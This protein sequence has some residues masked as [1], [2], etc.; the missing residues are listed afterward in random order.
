VALDGVHA[1]WL[2]GRSYRVH[3]VDAVRS[4]CEPQLNT[5]W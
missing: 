5:G 1:A 4:M 2:A 3:L